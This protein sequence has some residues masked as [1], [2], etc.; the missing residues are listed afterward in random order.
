MVECVGGWYVRGTEWILIF[1]EREFEG[2]GPRFV[3]IMVEGVLTGTCC[4]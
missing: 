2:C 1:I 4:I 3:H